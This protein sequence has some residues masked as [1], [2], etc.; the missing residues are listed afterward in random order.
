MDFQDWGEHVQNCV[1]PQQ[2]PQIGKPHK[3]SDY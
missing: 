1:R 2:V 3:N